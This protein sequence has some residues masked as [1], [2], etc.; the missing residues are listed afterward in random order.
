MKRELKDDTVL[1][2]SPTF[3]LSRKAHPDEKGTESDL[4]CLL[5]FPALGRKAHPDEKG[6]ESLSAVP[7][8]IQTPLVA[9]LI[10]MKRELKGN[11]SNGSNGIFEIVARLIPMK[12]ELKEHLL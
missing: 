10:P 3:F 11:R 5:G 8:P 4:R 12:R 1:G 6:T 7:T 9:R 2:V